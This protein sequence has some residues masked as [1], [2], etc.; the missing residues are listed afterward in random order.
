MGP[1]VPRRGHRLDF[2]PPG[3]RLPTRYYRELEA[4]LDSCWMLAAFIG[5]GGRSIAFVHLT[6]PRSARPFTVDDVQRLD[7]LPPARV[8]SAPIPGR[9]GA[10]W[11]I[12]RHGKRVG[13]ERSGGL[14]VRR[15]DRL[16]DQWPRIPA[17]DPT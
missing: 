11:R 10:G 6:R 7:R 8:S 2:A 9:M 12:I 5:D 3:P 13:L 15:E 14:D 16:S 1:C 17:Q 4:P